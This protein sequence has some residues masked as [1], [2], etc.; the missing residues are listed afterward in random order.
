LHIALVARRLTVLSCLSLLL[1]STPAAAQDRLC[2]PG[3]EDCRALLID[4]IRAEQ[5]GLDVAFWF[6]E[7][8]W[9]ASEIIN[10][11]KAGVPVRVLM[12]TEANSPNP[13]NADRLAELAA[14][15]IPMRERIAGGILHWKMM[16]FAGQNMVQFSAAN[17]S[18]DAW[19][20]SGAP[21][22]NYT[23]EVIFFTS[24]GAIV[25]SFRTKYD[26]LWLDTSYYRDYANVADRVRVYGT[27]PIDP[28]LNFVP[29][30]SHANRAVEVFNREP[31]QID[32]IMYRITDSRYADA[33][34]AAVQRGVRVRLLTEPKQ[35]RDPL[36]QFHSYN[37]DRMFMAGV[38]IRHRA[39]AGLIHQKSVILHG[40]GTSVFGS[41]NW[42]SA[43]SESQEEHNFFTEDDWIYDWLTTQ[44]ERKWNNLTGVAESGPFAP[45]PPDVPTAPSPASGAAGVDGTE[46]TLQ[47]Y[48]GFWAHKYDVYLGLHPASLVRVASDLAVGPSRSVGE[49]KS[50]TVTGL[51][52][53]TMYYWKVE[54]KS[55]ANQVS[56]GSLWSFTTAGTAPPPATVTL[57]REPYLQQVTSTSALVVWATREPG[58]AQLRVTPPVGPTTTVPAVSTRYAATATGLAYDY[59]QHVASVSGLSP[60]TTFNYDILVDGVDLNATADTLTTAPGAGGTVSFVAFGDSGTGSAAQQQIAGLLAA[61]PFDFAL[62]AGDIAY[63]NSAGTGGATHQTMED[64]FFSMYRTW[65]RSRPVFPSIG[66]HDSRAANAD[67]RPYLDMYELPTHGA[68]GAYP[69]HAERYYSFDY[70]PVHVIVLDTELAFQDPARRA[71]QLAW[72]DADLAA[73][74]QPWKVALYHRS[75]YSAGGENGS[76]L[77]VRAAFAPLFDKHNVQLALSAHEHDYERTVPLRADQPDETGTVYVVSGGG[78][79]PLYPSAYAA[80]TAHSASVHH[81]VRGTATECTLR[82]EAV[83]T[84]GVAF[85]GVTLTRCEPQPD[86]APPTAAITRPAAGATVK[87]V[88]TITAS[89]TDDVGVERV[90]F[91]V[92]GAL[93]HTDTQAPFSFAWDSTAVPNGAHQLTARAADAA[94][95]ATTSSP[96]TIDV[97]NVAAGAGDIVLYAADTTVISGRWQKEADAT[98]AGGFRLRNPDAGA[99]KRVTP[100]ANPADYFELTIDPQPNVP[101]RFWMR[102]KADGNTYPNDSVFVQFTGTNGFGIGTTSATE[103]NLEDCSGCRVA[104]WGWQDNAWGV[105]VPS[106]PIV[107]TTP[108]PHR[109]RIQVREDGLSIDQIMFSPVTFY[110]TAPGA[111]QGDTTIYPRSAGGPVTEPPPQEEPV[112]QDPPPNAAPTV[113]LTQ[114][115]DGSSSV[116]P[117]TITLAATAADS[118]GTIVRVDFYAGAT[119]VA[120]AASS[121]YTAAWSG[122]AA[123]TYSIT[124]RA[125]DDDGAIT[126]SAQAVVTVTTPAPEPEPEPEPE[127]VPEPEVLPS[128]WTAQDIGAV[129]APGSGRAASGTFTLAGAG[130]DIWNGAD[131]FHYVWQPLSGDADVVARVSTIE[132]VHAWVKAGVM[133][134]ERLTADAPHALMLVSP[135]KGLA[136]QRRRAAAGASTSTSG[137]AGTAPAWV[138]LERRGNTITAYRSDDGI[139]WALVGSDTFTMPDTVYVGLV[140]SSH[141]YGR[142]ATAAFDNVAIT[143]RGGGPAA[144]P[145]AAPV[146]ELTSPVA[147]AP[148]TAPATIAVAATASDP[149]GSVTRVEF[150]A[151]STLIG[152]SAAAPFSA[153]WSNVPAGTYTLTARAVDDGGAIAVS[154]PVSVTVTAPVPT[155]PAEWHGQD[156]GA[157]GRA[158][159]AGERDGVFTVTG[160]GID[161]WN[162]ADAFHYV[163]QPVSGDVD[164]VARVTS[165]ENVHAWVKAGVM[166]REALTAG[167]AHALMLV[168][169]GKGLAFQRRPVTGGIST[170]TTGGA[171]TAPAW[172]KLERRGGVITAFR[173]ADGVQWTLVGSDTFTMAAD[174]YVGLAVS[175]HV[176]NRLATATFEHVVVTR[177]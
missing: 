127:P 156:I 52:P 99:A 28:R 89:A 21:Y 175:S 60:S 134:R 83:D 106:E 144:P 37:V 95:N 70:G 11:H 34:I 29:T 159:V 41:S 77:P 151:G 163:W 44:F 155:L 13:M 61:D 141:V 164:I 94:G 162:A 74:A 120:S 8:H 6:M 116:A 142:L 97:Q 128:P 168:S 147:G 36:R 169:P 91:L 146:V 112:P 5:V 43:S 82:L 110:S 25:D 69:D 81:Y 122:V 71:A 86:T 167:S 98:A 138:K 157:V 137:G 23:D 32:V 27:F 76:E 7:D 18:S 135:G 96:L 38:E 15:K 154:A 124:A 68:T 121:P 63:A 4:R 84:A 150:Y 3:A 113:Q 133:I 46:L 12:D 51:Q 148:F 66:N 165:V 108:G 130:A 131:A 149:D 55:V 115:A 49:A 72:A 19:V 153:S 109:I 47:W 136:F 166:V 75:A 78:G 1:F 160:E 48:P 87:G 173:S 176:N 85:D 119:L 65:L 59:Y 100:L 50:F 101:Y 2:D 170:S 123:G 79:A 139:S 145:N 174:V 93:V 20:Y 114:P 117:A 9:I 16:L 64:W 111:L 14:A 57:A 132:N 24:E 58:A 31:A 177:R 56:S 161:I 88:V 152:S 140:V 10:R 158:G 126:S 92:D 143:P 80:W 172:V 33:M 103:Y 42:S 171:G 30:E 45:L 40:L 118:D 39:H 54:A 125:V 129:G 22:T 17:Y 26:D 73:T 102:G 67:G 90:E 107:F 105:G 104:D 53:G 62:H 35:Y